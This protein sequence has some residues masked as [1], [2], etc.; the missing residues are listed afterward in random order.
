[1]HINRAV[2]FVRCGWCEGRQAETCKKLIVWLKQMPHTN[3]NHYYY[4]H[5]CGN[6]KSGQS[7]HAVDLATTG[8]QQTLKPKN[9]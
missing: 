5:F 3:N 2:S 9:R 1:M 8:I 4:C 7:H 6:G